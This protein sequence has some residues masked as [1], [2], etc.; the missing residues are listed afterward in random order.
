[1]PLELTPKVKEE[2]QARAITYNVLCGIVKLYGEATLPEI[3]AKY[4]KHS[5]TWNLPFVWVSEESARAYLNNG[6]KNGLLRYER[7]RKG[8]PYDRRIDGMADGV[9][10]YIWIGNDSE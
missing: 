10:Y 7:R 8:K 5:R 6:V 3:R 9:G 4:S 1:M 2:M